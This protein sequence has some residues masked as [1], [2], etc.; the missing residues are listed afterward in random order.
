MTLLHEVVR[1][2]LLVWVVVESRGSSD[3]EVP[4]KEGR[5]VVLLGVVGRASR[6]A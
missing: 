2:P 3:G 5:D 4:E 6:V 1:E